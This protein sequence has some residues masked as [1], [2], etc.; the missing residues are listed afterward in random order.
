[1]WPGLGLY[2]VK[3]LIFIL[4]YEWLP[5]V[6]LLPMTLDI[7]SLKSWVADQSQYEYLQQ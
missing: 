5:T 3:L 7:V 6:F 2:R 4:V 1:M